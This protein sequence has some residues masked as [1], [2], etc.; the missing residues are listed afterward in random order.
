MGYSSLYVKNAAGAWESVSIYSANV[1]IVDGGNGAYTLTADLLCYNNTLYKVTLIVPATD[2]YKYDEASD[3]TATF[4]TYTVDESRLASMGSV[5]VIGQNEQGQ[6][7][8]MD[9]ILSG[10]ATGLEP[11]TY[12]ID[13]TEEVQTVFAGHYD[14]QE[15]LVPSYAG[16]VEDQSL[17]NVW[18]LV[19]GTVTVDDNLNIVVNALNSKG[20]AIT[21]ALTAPEKPTGLEETVAAGKAAKILR[22]GQ[23]YILKGDKIF[24]I[25]GAA[26]R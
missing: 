1:T 22:N 7:I 20:N 19:S 21:V 4:S 15:G 5:Y 12:S 2:P 14:A 9:V 13:N 26:I 25:M 10:T 11:G 3:F 24:N 18:Y 8:M 16:M 17:T 23:I 6:V